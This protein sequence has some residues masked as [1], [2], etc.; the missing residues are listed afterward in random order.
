M[1]ADHHVVAVREALGALSGV[2]DIRAS[3]AF[4]EVTVDHTEKVTKKALT[5][6]LE[7]AGYPVGEEKPVEEEPS[8]LGDPS[9]YTCAP[10]SIRTEA[11]DLE[12]SGDFRLY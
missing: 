11:V 9:W 10:R 2:K 8:H 5:E 12:M 6:A 1:Y 4:K 7:K 3:A